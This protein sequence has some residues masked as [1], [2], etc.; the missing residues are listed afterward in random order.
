MAYRQLRVGLEASKAAPAAADFYVG[1]LNARKRA[2]S[3]LSFDKWLLPLYRWLGGYGVRPF[4]P[5]ISLVGVVLLTSLA[6]NKWGSLVKPADPK[7]VSGYDISKYPEALAVILRNSVS[8]V[9]AP[10]DGLTASGT[11][12]LVAE[13]FV[14]VAL[15]AM[16]VLAVRSRVAR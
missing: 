15:L 6:L 1:E 14:A 4:P 2:A 12:L 3:W 10:A 16:V 8:L 13:R 5:L 7:V 9:S 11:F